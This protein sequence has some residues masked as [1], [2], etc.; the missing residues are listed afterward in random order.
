MADQDDNQ[1]AAVGDEDVEEKTTVKGR[2][3]RKTGGTPAK[4]SVK[5]VADKVASKV[6]KRK[7]SDADDVDAAVEAEGSSV[8]KRGRGRPPGPGKP[9]RGRPRTKEPAPKKIVLGP[10]GKPRGRGRPKKVKKAFGG[11]KAAAA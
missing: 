8:A 2:R 3:G 4:N 1:L 11:R 6:E 10:D 9:G 7:R 5:K